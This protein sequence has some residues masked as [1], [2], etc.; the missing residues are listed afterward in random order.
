MAILMVLLALG[1][2]LHA[3]YGSSRLLG[4][5]VDGIAQAQEVRHPR[6]DLVSVSQDSEEESAA[7]GVTASHARQSLQDSENETPADVV[8]TVVVVF[9]A[10]SHTFVAPWHGQTSAWHAPSTYA[11]GFPPP[12]HAPPTLTI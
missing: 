5:H 7:V 11:L 3:H 12:A 2:F 6:F 4:F 8:A 9:A 10:V 1:P